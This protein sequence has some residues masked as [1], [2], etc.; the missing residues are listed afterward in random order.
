MPKKTSAPDFFWLEPLRVLLIRTAPRHPT[1]LWWQKLIGGSQGQSLYETENFCTVSGADPPAWTFE[2]FIVY[3][4]NELLKRW[5]EKEM[6]D[7]YCEP[8]GGGG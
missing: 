2:N 6:H 8:G 3:G 7:L 4:P 5:A 1:F